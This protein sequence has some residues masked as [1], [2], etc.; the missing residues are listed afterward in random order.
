MGTV[1]RGQKGNHK[2]NSFPFCS[3]KKWIL[4]LRNKGNFPWFGSAPIAKGT[5]KGKI[6]GRKPLL[7]IS[8]IEQWWPWLLEVPG[9]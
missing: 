4:A 5:N 9:M 7:E 2:G 6:K 1:W 8:W 3:A